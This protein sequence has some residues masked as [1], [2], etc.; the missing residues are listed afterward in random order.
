MADQYFTFSSLAT[1]AGASGATL[2]ITNTLKQAF[3]YSRKWVG[4][5]VA[6]VISIGLVLQANGGGSDLVLAALNG[7]LVYLTAAGASDAVGGGQGG[8]GKT[9]AVPRSDWDGG[10]ATRPVGFFGSW[11]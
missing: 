9:G 8:A 4:L 6:Q 5:I 10:G 11:F 1:L 7:C 3:D 2:I